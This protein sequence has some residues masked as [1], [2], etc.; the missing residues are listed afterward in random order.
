MEHFKELVIRL[1][2]LNIDY[3]ADMGEV[4]GLTPDNPLT[5][6]SVPVEF[7]ILKQKALLDITILEKSQI[8]ALLRNLYGLQTRLD[9][10]WDRFNTNIAVPGLDDW[11]R[12]YESLML[13]QIFFIHKPA[14]KKKVEVDY[15]FFSDLRV[16]IQWREELLL[17]FIEEIEN[18]IAIEESGE[19]EV[20]VEDVSEPPCRKICR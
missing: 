11:N 9:I 8:L 5:N 16:I 18:L 14:V 17:D 13:D 10:F 12:Y 1:Q 20:E 19:V 4:Y 2:T 3:N 6:S 15:A 7:A